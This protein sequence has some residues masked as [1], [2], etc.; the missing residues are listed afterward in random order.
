MFGRI[1]ALIGRVGEVISGV[2]GAVGR[3]VA[4]LVAPTGP[5]P[6]APPESRPVTPPP[7]TVAPPP[8]S[9][10][11]TSP[12]G[13]V[14]AP[15]PGDPLFGIPV[16]PEAFERHPGDR[17]RYQIEVTWG[18]R[19]RNVVDQVW[20]FSIWS[21][22]ELSES[23]LLTETALLFESFLPSATPPFDQA[24]ADDILISELTVLD[25]IRR[26]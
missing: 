3:A 4:S 1:G 20:S 10:P 25:T 11:P 6:V 15:P 9:P 13:V 5:G 26:Y 7:A 24:T 12:P 22:D 17:F 14:T 21:P 18:T 16:V 8:V 19:D 2:V 23:D